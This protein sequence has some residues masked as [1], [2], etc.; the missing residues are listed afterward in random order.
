MKELKKTSAELE[1][2]VLDILY[3]DLQE[4]HVRVGNDS[5]NGQP[6]SKKF[7]LSPGKGSIL[8]RTI[9]CQWDGLRIQ[10]RWRRYMAEYGLLTG[11]QARP[12][13]TIRLCGPSPLQST[14]AKA[15]WYDAGFV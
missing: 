8:L 5:T 13:T 15:F 12:H 4:I 3:L 9:D 7:C 11:R 2:A 6:V 10:G 14:P 1:L